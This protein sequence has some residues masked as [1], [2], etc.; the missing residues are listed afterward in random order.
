MRW[1]HE[2]ILIPTRTY[3]TRPQHT[4]WMVAELSRRWARSTMSIETLRSDRDS[5]LALEAEWRNPPI[6]WSRGFGVEIS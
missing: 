6:R 3:G 4:K 2:D 1:G 5:F